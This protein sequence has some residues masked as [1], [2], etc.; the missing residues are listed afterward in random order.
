MLDVVVCL[1]PF[2]L[3]MRGCSSIA[4]GG[5]MIVTTGTEG[6]GAL[7]SSRM[8]FCGDILLHLHV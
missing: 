2:L 6:R 4:V 1:L 3:I 8:S 5:I 7:F